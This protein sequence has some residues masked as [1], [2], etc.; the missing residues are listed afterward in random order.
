MDVAF[1]IQHE[2]FTRFG[3]IVLPYHPMV[4]FTQEINM[5]EKA[6]YITNRHDSD[7]IFQGKWIGKIL[8]N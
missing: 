3:G 4:S 8:Y 6:G 5:L 7:I 1:E 2:L